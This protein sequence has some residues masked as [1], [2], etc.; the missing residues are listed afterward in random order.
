MATIYEVLL[1]TAQAAQPKFPILDA[2]ETDAD[3]LARLAQAVSGVTKE[4][5]ESMAL[6]AQEWFDRAA[7]ALNTGG[8]IPHPDGYDRNVVLTP[9]NQHK[10]K[11][12]GRPTKSAPALA[13]IEVPAPA[14][15]PAPAKPKKETAKQPAKEPV[16]EPVKEPA[17]ALS[18]RIRQM[19]VDTYPGIELTVSDV[20]T[21]LK[22][23]G[24]EV[25]GRRSTISTLRYD[26]LTTLKMALDSGW[27]PR[28]QS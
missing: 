11:V 23:A 22:S 10:T 8:D 13:P 18:T 28:Q 21:K 6:N 15:E 9:I 4:A 3:Y 16:K 12:M 20:I 24:V 14:P 5:F 2:K 25:G 7:D 27:Q 17:I 19:M 1:T 26:T